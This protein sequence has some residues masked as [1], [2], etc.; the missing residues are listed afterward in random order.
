MGIPVDQYQKLR[1]VSFHIP[2]YIYMPC[3]V[4]VH[5]CKYH[6]YILLSAS[7]F[8]FWECVCVWAGWLLQ[9]PEKEEVHRSIFVDVYKEYCIFIHYFED[10]CWTFGTCTINHICV[11]TQVDIAHILCIA[12][13]AFSPIT[14]M[15]PFTLSLLTARCCCIC[16]YMMSI[17]CWVCVL[18]LRKSVMKSVCVDMYTHTS[19]PFLNIFKCPEYLKIV[20]LGCIC[21]LH[22]NMPNIL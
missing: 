4:A 20:C 15:P 3:V 18:R 5:P 6:L 22:S 21:P 13:F 12:V 11:C 7:C 16:L 1:A 14:A 2:T 19:T 17:C 9:C 8:V 10:L